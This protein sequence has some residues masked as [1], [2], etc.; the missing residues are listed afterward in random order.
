M[1]DTHHSLI[2]SA[3]KEVSPERLQ[4]AVCGL[5]DGSLTITPT[6]QTATELRGLVK[7]GDGTEYGCTLAAAVTTCS[8]KDALYRGVV[9]KHATAL[10]LY[11]LRTPEKNA[12]LPPQDPQRIKHLMWTNGTILCG[13]RQ[14]ETVWCWPWP[15]SIGN[16][17]HWPDICALCVTARN[18]PGLQLVKT[19][20]H[21][22][23]AAGRG[24]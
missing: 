24:V 10:A 5:A 17:A 9:C 12:A 4:K 6:R 11:V 13:A 15:D 14:A 20:P 16:A 19:S 22:T 18:H 23:P 2:L 7:N 8:C 21:W 1:S 3:L